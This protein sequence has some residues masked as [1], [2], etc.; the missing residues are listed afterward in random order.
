MN[1]L[2]KYFHTTSMELS[3]TEERL[4]ELM[5]VIDAHSVSGA[6]K[7]FVLRDPVTDPKL[8]QKMVAVALGKTVLWPSAGELCLTS[9]AGQLSLLAGVHAH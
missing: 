9:G 8:A 6:R 3:Q 4:L 1:L 2:R 5:Q 7:H